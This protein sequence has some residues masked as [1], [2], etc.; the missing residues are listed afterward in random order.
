MD[1]I[2]ALPQDANY[3]SL[4]FFPPKTEMVL[5]PPNCT[6]HIRSNASTQGTSNLQARLARM[7]RALRPLFVTVTWGA[8]GSTSARSLELAEIC[9]RQLG[10]TTCLHLTCTNMNKKIIDQTLAEAKDIGIRN[11]LA[12]RGDPPR[13]HEYQL[14]G[15]EFEGSE[16]FVWAVDLV[17]YIRQEY[18]DYFCIGVAGYPEGHSDESHPADQDPKHD[19]PYLEEKVLAGADFIMTQLFYDA[20]AY[21]SYEKLVKSYNNGVLKDYTIIP[22][23]MPIQSYQVLK[24]TTVLSHAKLPRDIIEHLEP[25]KGN[26]EEVKRVGVEILA[27]VIKKI[28][29]KPLSSS[30]RRGF[31]FYTLNLEK[32]VSF[33]LERCKLI[34]PITPDPELS[35]AIDDSDP[36]DPLP[37]PNGILPHI[38]G[39]RRPS[40]PHNHVTTD[41]QRSASTLEPPSRAT[42]LAITHGVGSLG[43]EATW[44]DYPNGRFGDA[45]SP[46]FGEIDGYG[47]SLHLSPSAARSKWGKPATRGGIGKLF[48]RHL[49]GEL[50]RL[51]WSEGDSEIALSAETKIIEKQLVALIEH[52]GWWS[53]ASQPACNGVRSD[54]VAFGWGPKGGFVFQKAFVEFW[55]SE[56]DWHNTL[57]PHLEKSDIKDEV[58]WYA[59]PCPLDSPSAKSLP[60]KSSEPNSNGEREGKEGREDAKNQTTPYT[61]LFESSNSSSEVNSVTWGSFPGKEII[62]PTIIEEI[63]FRAW[64]DEAFGIWKEW[65]ACYPVGSETREVLRNCREEMW[66]VNVISHSYQEPEAL[67]DTLMAA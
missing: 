19:M 51:P 27:S 52:R 26:D 11:I 16:Q 29:N 15:N 64:A 58:S 18:G 13:G 22:G 23:I 46:A 59:S 21:L 50:D 2:A 20:E 25:I 55:I 39:I 66:L 65:E 8:G 48:V 63:S 45:R 42:T 24:R 61:P 31:H 10:L 41:S 6:N 38:P 34:P 57:K 7:S 14:E 43:R 35:S 54:H 37:I 53:I 4:E 9:Q 12:L 33:L 44:D 36:I 67:W 3:C 49:R 5:L 28:K 1:K 62:T 17:R 60:N 32:A 47:T 30:Q 56:K 40:T